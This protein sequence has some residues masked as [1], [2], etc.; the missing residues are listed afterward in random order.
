MSEGPNHIRIIRALFN[1]NST[2]TNY[3]FIKVNHSEHLPFDGSKKI[4]PPG[5]TR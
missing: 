4:L 2:I 1:I 3:L 5:T